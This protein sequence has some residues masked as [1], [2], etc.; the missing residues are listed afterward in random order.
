MTSTT[1]ITYICI[2]NYRYVESQVEQKKIQG[3]EKFE[4]L[5]FIEIKKKI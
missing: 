2:G 3:N 4:L 1:T 5:R